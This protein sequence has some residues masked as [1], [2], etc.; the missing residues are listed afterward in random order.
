M[1]SKPSLLFSVTLAAFAF[2]PPYHLAPHFDRLLLAVMC[3]ITVWHVLLTRS[4]LLVIEP[5]IV[6]FALL[7][8]LATGSA[9]LQQYRAQTWS[10]V[11]A[12]YIVPLAMFVLARYI[13]VTGE[14]VQRLFT[15]ATILLAYLIFTAVAWMAGLDALVFPRF[16][17]DPSLGIMVDRARGPFL[18]AVANG[19]ALTILGLLWWYRWQQQGFRKGWASIWAAGLPPAIIATLTRSVWLAFATSFAMVTIGSPNRTA[20]RLGTLGAIFAAT[21]AATLL[22]IPPFHQMIAKRTEERSPVEFRLAVYRAAVGM[23]AEEPVLGYGTNTSADLLRNYVQGYDLKV[24][25]A[26]NT[27]LEV[28]LEHGLIGLGLLIA[29]LVLL[30]RLGRRLPDGPGLVAHAGLTKEFR[31][32]WHAILVV[33]IINGMFVIMNYVF[34][35]ALL[36]SVAG[37][38]CAQEA[39]SDAAVA[40]RAP[41]RAVKHL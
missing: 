10:V 14:A 27:Y 23:F 3:V 17:L 39:Q 41:L 37:M 7:T 31:L 20:R 1:L 34:I 29:T 5:V 11:A 12:E 26:H 36:F 25:P 18:Q 8:L 21:M 32:T 15:I 40:S 19:S 33:Y 24:A 35:N 30:W 38:I 9:A 13:F 22:A 6:P 16:I 28:T 2:F 4:P